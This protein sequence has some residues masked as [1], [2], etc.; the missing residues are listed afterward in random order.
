MSAGTSWADHWASDVWAQLGKYPL[1]TQSAITSELRAFALGKPLP[2]RTVEDPDGYTKHVVY[3]DVDGVV[4]EV[5]AI[6]HGDMVN[7]RAITRGLT[8]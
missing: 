5:W 3:V 7:V 1:A 4:Y 2:V 8:D 6:I